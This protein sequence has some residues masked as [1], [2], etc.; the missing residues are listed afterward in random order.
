MRALVIESLTSNLLVVVPLRRIAPYSIVAPDVE[1]VCGWG[2]VV[3]VPISI[4]KVS[5]SR[6]VKVML[7][8][9]LIVYKVLIPIAIL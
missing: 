9:I 1:K 7:V 5:S 3:G 8:V 6:L 4:P 2:L